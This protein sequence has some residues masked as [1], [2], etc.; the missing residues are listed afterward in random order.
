MENGFSVAFLRL[1]DLLAVLKRDAE[2]S[3]QRLRRRKHMNVALLVIDEVG[4]EPMTRQEASL[5]FRLVSY[6]YGRGSMLITTVTSHKDDPTPGAGGLDSTSASGKPP[7]AA[8]PR[9]RGGLEGMLSGT[10]AFAE[11]LALEDDLVGVVSEA[12]QG[13]LS[14]DRILEQG[15]PLVERPVAGKDRRAAS[16]ALEND[17]V[18]IP[19]LLGGEAAQA[20]VIDDQQRRREQ[21]AQHGLAGVVGARLVELSPHLVGAHEEHALAGPA[22]GVAEGGGQEGFTHAHGA[23][24]E[25]VLAALEE[26]Q[27][28]EL[29]DAIAIE[30]DRGLPVEVFEGLLLLEAGAGEAEGEVFVIAA[31]DLVLEHELEEVELREFCL[32]CVRDPIGERGEQSREFQALHHAPQRRVDLHGVSPGGWGNG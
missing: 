23:E 28:E 21:A 3:P 10:L 12:V 19:G 7:G 20:E 2:V 27:A 9:S 6:R 18:E 24:Q 30:G 1:E 31:I 25:D 11:A 22:G 15:D 29:L 17:L 13:A 8:A 5:F 32:L 14:Q 4:F 16:M 26:A